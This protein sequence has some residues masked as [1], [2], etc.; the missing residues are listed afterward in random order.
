MPGSTIRP[1]T[2]VK[3]TSQTAGRLLAGLA[4]LV[5]FAVISL[6]AVR[7]AAEPVPTPLGDLEDAPALVL[8]FDDNVAKEMGANEI[9][10]ATI[11]V[12]KYGKLLFAKGYGSGDIAGSRPVVASE[13]LF[14]IGSVTKLFTWTAVMQLVEAGQLD[15]NTDVNSYLESLKIP[16][17]Y[18]QPITWPI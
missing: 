4:M 14:R 16:D 15:L 9:P 11:S 8:Y 3:S 17:T 7:A 6:L 10:G 2:S 18:P 1:I 5:V 13:T 12:V